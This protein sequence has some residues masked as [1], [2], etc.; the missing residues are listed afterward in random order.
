MSDFMERAAAEADRQWP[1]TPHPETAME[2]G[3][4]AGAEWA[5]RELLAE[6]D[7]LAA[8]VERVCPCHGPAKSGDPS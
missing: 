7:S 3:F 8:T 5:R 6:R 2:Q 4:L 1:H